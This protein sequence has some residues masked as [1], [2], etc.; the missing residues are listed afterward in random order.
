M[1]GCAR[2]V[3]A[4]PRGRAG[5]CGMQQALIGFA[6][7]LRRI[8]VSRPLPD[9]ADHVDEPVAVRRKRA[10][11]RGA[12]RSRLSARFCQGN[13]PC[14]VFAMWRPP[15]MKSSPQ[16]NGALRARRAPQTPTPLRSAASCRPTPRMPPRRRT[17]RGQPGAAS[18]P[19]R[20]SCRVRRGWRQSAPRTN[21]HQWLRSRRL[22]GPG[23][24]TNTSEPAN[25]ISCS[26]PG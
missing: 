24:W 7:M 10:D 19:V 23:G 25:S 18:R 3:A 20:A 16:A 8:P 9:V 13:S 21:C 11:R 5:C 1:F 4:R 22:T 2:V 12:A 14:Q 6:G 26:A 15:T 17:S